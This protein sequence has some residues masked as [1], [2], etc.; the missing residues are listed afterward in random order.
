MNALDYAY[1][2]LE[3]SATERKQKSLD[4]DSALLTAFVSGFEAAQQAVAS[5]DCPAP[6]NCPG[7]EKQLELGNNCPLGNRR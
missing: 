4:E 3:E 5:D 6:N 2:W 1:E 7:C